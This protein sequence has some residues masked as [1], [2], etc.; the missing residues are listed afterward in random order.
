M[1]SLSRQSSQESAECAAGQFALPTDAISVELFLA[2]ANA[3]AGEL[4]PR[5]E[6][7]R[8]SIPFEELARRAGR[9]SQLGR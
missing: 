8:S 4:W 5:T 9:S 7:T 6:V 2:V 1:H 3:Q